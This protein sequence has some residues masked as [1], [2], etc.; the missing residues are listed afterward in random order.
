MA[1]GKNKT[2]GKI[3]VNPEQKKMLQAAQAAPVEKTEETAA[4]NENEAVTTETVQTAGGDD[5]TVTGNAAAAEAK[6]VPVKVEIKDKRTSA[7]RRADRKALRDKALDEALEKD[8]PFFEGYPAA[9]FEEDYD[10]AFAEATTCEK[11]IPA[12]QIRA[13]KAE[14]AASIAKAKTKTPTQELV[15]AAKASQ[16]ANDNLPAAEMDNTETLSKDAADL[17]LMQQADEL[18]KSPVA[19]VAEGQEVVVSYD[20]EIVSEKVIGETTTE[21]YNGIDYVVGADGK[22]VREDGESSKKYG[23]RQHQFKNAR[24]TAKRTADKAAKVEAASEAELEGRNGNP[25]S[26]SDINKNLPL[27]IDDEGNAITTAEVTPEK[28]ALESANVIEQANMDDEVHVDDDL[29]KAGSFA[30][31]AKTEEKTYD[32]NSTDPNRQKGEPKE[33]WKLRKN[34]IMAARA[35]EKQNELA[36]NV[37]TETPV[38]T[39]ETTDPQPDDAADTDKSEVPN[40]T[41]VDTKQEPAEQTPPVVAQAIPAPK[42]KMTPK[43]VVDNEK[44][45]AEDAKLAEKQTAEQRA[46]AQKFYGSTWSDQRATKLAQAFIWL[47]KATEADK[48]LRDKVEFEG[49]VNLRTKF[50][51][52]MNAALKFEANALGG[53]PQQITVEEITGLYGPE[54]TAAKAA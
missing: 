26:P 13:A 36:A 1:K 32:P 49:P 17:A 42:P 47:N 54:K 53:A 16:S 34:R 33:E 18:D 46:A 23:N 15:E 10:K 8:L 30:E 48:K 44:D 37:E 38:S 24:Y 28:S 43:L 27:D 12:A 14:V 20:G 11:A 52:A 35:K 51:M 3:K 2:P 31:A 25:P 45:A 7:Q 9:K 41:P 40:N 5:V 50:R 22:L 4:A 21:T 29:V 19:V 6:D 39:P